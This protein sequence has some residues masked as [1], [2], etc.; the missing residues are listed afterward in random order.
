[1]LSQAKALL[2]RIEE[3]FLFLTDNDSIEN[4]SHGIKNKKGNRSR[5]KRAIDWDHISNQD[6]HI[7]HKLRNFLL[8]SLK[9]DFEAEKERKEEFLSLVRRGK[10]C[11]L[12]H[13]KQQA[14]ILSKVN[15]DICSEVEW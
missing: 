5:R 13:R 1:M 9:G 12:V 3:T 10:V 11:S 14:A 8:Y 7:L 2:D 4:R 6:V 15:M